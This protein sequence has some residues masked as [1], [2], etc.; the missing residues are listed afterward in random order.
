MLLSSKP[1]GAILRLTPVNTEAKRAFNDVAVMLGDKTERLNL[2]H[3]SRFMF[4]EPYR[5]SHQKV[6]DTEDRVG[7]A[8]PETTDTDTVTE[9]ESDTT[10]EYELQILRSFP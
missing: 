4:I 8:D 3:A 5:R 9:A 2:L 10:A 7:I 1:P 6:P